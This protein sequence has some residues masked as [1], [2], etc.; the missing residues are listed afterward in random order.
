MAEILMDRQQL[1]AYLLDVFP[2]LFPTDHSP[3]DVV[4]IKENEAVLALQANETHLRPGGTVS[5]PALMTLADL[6]MYVVILGHI[7]TV[8]LAVTTNLNIN[9]MRK[10]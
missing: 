10:Q 2:E 9:F 6:A 4:S 5:G 3:Y 1:N 7:G 8:D